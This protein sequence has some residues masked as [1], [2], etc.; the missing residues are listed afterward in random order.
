MKSISIDNLYN[1]IR[2]K[3]LLAESYT[4]YT[5]LSFII[6]ASRLKPSDNNLTLERKWIDEYG[7][8]LNIVKNKKIKIIKNDLSIDNTQ[9]ICT[10][11]YDGLPIYKIGKVSKLVYLLTGKDED[12]QEE[13]LIIAFLGI[14]N[15][16][17]VYYIYDGQM[18]MTSPLSLGMKVLKSIAENRDIKYF[19]ELNNKELVLFPCINQ[20]SW[21]SF[22]PASNQFLE[23]I[24][25]EC[26]LFSQ[27]LNINN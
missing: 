22:Y 24:Y 3:I 27:L 7:N 5:D 21:I 10:D 12:F 18:T 9:L 20:K 2:Q 23:I 16:L 4:E 8:S 11:L 19:T 26:E 17:R 14:D 15:F 6:K 25:K 1:K 13:H